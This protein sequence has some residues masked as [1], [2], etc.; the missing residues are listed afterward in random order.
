MGWEEDADRVLV[1]GLEPVSRIV[2]ADYDPT[3][4]GRFEVERRRIATALADATVRIEHIG[5]T[6]IRGLAAKP[7]IDIL[8][9]VA[10]VD[11]DTSFA[12]ALVAAGYELRVR[13]PDHRMFR[14]PERDVHIHVYAEGSQ[15]IVDYLDLR[16]WLRG[17]AE[18]RE[19]YAAVKRALATRPWADMND[20]ADAKSDIVEDTLRRARDWRCARHRA[21]VQRLFDEVWNGRRFD[22]LDEL[23]GP[24]LVVD[25]RPYSPLGYGPQHIR[26]AVERAWAAFP[27]YHEEC[28]G[29]ITEGWRAAVHVRTTGTQDGQW[30]P[31]PPTGKRLKFEEIILLD[32]DDRGR[33]VRQRG[34]VDNLNALRQNGLI[35]TPR[36]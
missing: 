30:G 6:S 31:L 29:V 32:F 14:T 25:Y 17:D 33:V 22:A 8:V 21:V 9:V 11:D 20:Y 26:D 13:E 35:P 18:G 7:I 19:R 10:D 15:E 4:P 2:I 3:W 23:Y 1:G 34:I 28:L 5:S 16:D 12:P 36:P 27:D 24:D